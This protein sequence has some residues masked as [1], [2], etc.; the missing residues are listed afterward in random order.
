[1]I[2]MIVENLKYYMKEKYMNDMDVTLAQ[3]QF[4]I[5]FQRQIAYANVLDIDGDVVYQDTLHSC[6]NWC[7]TEGLNI[8]NTYDILYELVCKNGFGT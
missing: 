3:L 2:L 5:I 6:I 8:T 7:K 1:M 4:R